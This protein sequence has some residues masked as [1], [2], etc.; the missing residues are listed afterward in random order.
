MVKQKIIVNTCD[1]CENDYE[2][3]NTEDDYDNTNAIMLLNMD[4]NNS[5]YSHEP[6]ELCPDCMKSFRKWLAND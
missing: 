1:R 5:Y 2:T 4:D 3:Y 6:K